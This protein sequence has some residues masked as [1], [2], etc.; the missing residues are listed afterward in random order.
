MTDDDCVT[1]EFIDDET[2]SLNTCINALIPTKK[3]VV[4]VKAVPTEKSC[5]DTKLMNDFYR[6]KNSPDGRMRRC[7]SCHKE[8]SKAPVTRIYIAEKRCT[9]NLSDWVSVS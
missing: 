1:I 2:T 9:L 4:Y 5:K 6:D 3:E 8:K 7:K